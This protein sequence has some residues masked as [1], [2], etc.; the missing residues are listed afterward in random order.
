MFYVSG[1]VSWRDERGGSWFIR[2]LCRVFEKDGS[3]LDIM[4]LLTKVSRLVAYEY[5]SSTDEEE[6]NQKKQV[7][8][9]VSMLTK[10]L[11]L[12]RK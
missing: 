7:P 9:I 11:Y 3:R 8:S 2:S 4:A 10:R 6:M 1:Y 5:E 12:R